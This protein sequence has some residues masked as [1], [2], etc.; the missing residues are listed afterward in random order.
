MCRTVL[1]TRDHLTTIGEVQQLE[2]VSGLGEKVL[3]KVILMGLGIR[4]VAHGFW[5]RLRRRSV[6]CS[7]LRC[8]QNLVC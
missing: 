4:D 7:S 5:W 8:M 6:Y 3:L 1:T 2:K